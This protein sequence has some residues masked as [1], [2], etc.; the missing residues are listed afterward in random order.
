MMELARIYG[1]GEQKYDR[2]NYLKGYDWSL[3]VD[4]LLRHLYAFL[5]GEDRD[6]ES[7]LLH[8]AHVAWHGMTLTSFILRDVGTD[9]RAPTAEETE[10]MERELD[11][12]D[13]AVAAMGRAIAA[14][15]WGEGDGT[16]YGMASDE[17][18]ALGEGYIGFPVEQPDGCFLYR[19]IHVS[20]TVAT[21]ATFREIDAELR[22]RNG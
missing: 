4:A 19:G 3:S 14:E 21:A 8:T 2:Y 9:D 6:P 15:P 10:R 18:R 17:W 22:R 11:E 20:P 5:A 12:F 7:G 13:A 16:V 1:F